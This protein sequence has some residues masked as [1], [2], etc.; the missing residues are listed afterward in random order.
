LCCRSVSNAAEM[1]PVNN[2]GLEAVQRAACQPPRRA[3]TP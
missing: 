3:S 1:H 2:R